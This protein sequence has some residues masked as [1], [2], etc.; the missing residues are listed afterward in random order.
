MMA[1][2]ISS[3]AQDA[4]LVIAALASAITAVISAYNKVAISQTKDKVSTL[5]IAVN[6]RI[7]ELVEAKTAAAHAL[8][9]QEGAS[10]QRTR[11]DDPQPL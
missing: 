4:C 8:G 3:W 10:I 6:G 11:K 2:A 7:D 1:V 5:H 9:V